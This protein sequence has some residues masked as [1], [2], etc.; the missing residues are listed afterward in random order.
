MFVC[1]APALARRAHRRPLQLAQVCFFYALFYLFATR[2]NS[3]HFNQQVKGL[4]LRDLTTSQFNH[5]GR[6][7]D[8]SFQVPRE[9]QDMA[10]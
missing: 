3:S 6:L 2:W 8:T 4:D 1:G 9:L 5:F 10:S 7:M